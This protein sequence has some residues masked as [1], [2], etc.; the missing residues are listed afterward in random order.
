VNGSDIT[1]RFAGCPVLVVGD[2]MLDEF[3]WGQVS[4]ISPEA[5]VP[6]V[7]VSR[8]TFV[9]GGAANTAANVGSLGGKPVLAGVLGQDPD[10]ERVCELLRSQGVETLPVVRDP[11]RPTT[12]K[13]RVIAHSQ[14]VVRIDH[15]RPG[16]TPEAVEAALLARI[17][18]ALPTVR[19]CVVSDYGKGV[20]TPR[21][22]GQLLQL[23]RS[24]G[25][26]TVIDPKGLDYQKY[27]GATLVKP[28]QLEAGQ[29]LNRPLKTAEDVD[30][31]GADLSAL[32]GPET[33]VLITRGSHG[34]S[35]FERDRPPVHVPA[36]AREVYDVTGA[37]DTVAGTLGLALAVGATAEAACRL[38]SL[39]AA[40]VVGK[41]GTAT[42]SLTELRAAQQVARW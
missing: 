23:T 36:Q 40:V 7:E 32:L 13:T 25:V 20:V 42:C 34:M 31:A 39:A 26:P 35:L 29:V 22:V 17:G 24:A 3:V 14:Q 33:A 37:G 41:V 21:F 19:G 16:P 30:R 15:E 10:G 2:L 8:R 9:P 1:G 4:R 11:D 6:V 27:R 5:P 28:N 38:A 12:T 18:E